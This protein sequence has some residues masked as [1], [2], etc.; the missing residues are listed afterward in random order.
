MQSLW[1]LFAA[2]VFTVMGVCIKLATS[3]YSTSEIVMYRGL[4]G[5]LFMAGYIAYN[6]GTFRTSLP[7]QHLWRGVVG[8]TAMW[9]WFFSIGKLPLA[10]AMTLN[11]LSP[12]WIAAMLFIASLLKGNNRFE[13]GLVTAI[14]MS[15][16]GVVMLLQP[17]IHADQL[18]AG[19]IGLLSG[20]LAALAYLQVKRLGQMG[21]SE[22]RVV[23]YFSITGL[24]SG[25]LAT[26]YEGMLSS[27]GHPIWHAHT[28]RGILLLLTIGG[29]ATAAQVAMTRAYRLGKTLVTANL[30]YTGIIF[31]SIW[32]V[33]IWGD[34]LNRISW[35]GIVVIL[36]SGCTATYYNTRQNPATATAVAAQETESDPIASEL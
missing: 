29:C 32:G 31:S 6:R 11:Y 21:E 36:V 10:T 24:V 2:F 35:L 9:L 30:Q 25:L 13:W 28:P 4:V 27:H 33:V 19:L 34:T 20:F 8:V 23:F 17:S 7:W 1:M 22:S 15:F 5:V 12:V 16:I 26:L 14:V 18:I 3:S